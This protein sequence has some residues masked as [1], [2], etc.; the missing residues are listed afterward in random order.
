M[1]GTATVST[2]QGYRL[3]CGAGREGFAVI[4]PAEHRE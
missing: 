2:P 1:I 4:G 3:G